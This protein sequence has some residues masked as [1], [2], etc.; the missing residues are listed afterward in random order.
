MFW[1]EGTVVGVEIQVKIL[2]LDPPSRF[3]VT[4]GQGNALVDWKHHMIGV[5]VNVLETVL[6]QCRPVGDGG[7][8]IPS[9]D[10]VERRCVDPF[11]LNIVYLEPHVWWDP[12]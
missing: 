6:H 7:G 9:K 12:G 3:Q 4:V 8:K 1:P 2:K 10:E 11:T 5:E